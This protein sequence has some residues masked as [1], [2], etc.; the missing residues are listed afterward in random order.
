V[1]RQQDNILNWRYQDTVDLYY[2]GYGLF[3]DEPGAAILTAT[4]EK[5]K[6]C[7]RHRNGRA[8]NT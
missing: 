2:D 4:R 1:A 8:E 7:G 6:K 5:Y 3:Y